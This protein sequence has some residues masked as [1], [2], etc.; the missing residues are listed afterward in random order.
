MINLAIKKRTEKLEQ[1]AKEHHAHKNEFFAS[2]SKNGPWST[3]QVSVIGPQY[4]F[5]TKHFPKSLS[6]LIARTSS[7]K[8]R[9]LLVQI[10]YSELGGNDYEAAHHTLFYQALSSKGIEDKVIFTTPPFDET[11]SLV[12]GIDNLF[13]QE[14]LLMGLGAEYA[15]E[16]HADPMIEGLKNGFNGVNLQF[17]RVHAVDEPQH[18][19][20]V[21]ECLL[22]DEVAQDNWQLI[23]Y[24]AEKILELFYKFWMKIHK[25]LNSTRT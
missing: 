2:V 24:G 10:L 16:I 4:Y 18:I 12:E 8:T 11:H 21:R 17:F 6:K 14:P 3:E 20:N 23:E 15:L 13:A 19:I 9:N 22:G 1:Y 7:D 5:F 25:E